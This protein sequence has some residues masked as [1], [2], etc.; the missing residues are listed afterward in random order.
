VN[1]SED[2]KEEG[3]LFPMGLHV[4]RG[5]TQVALDERDDESVLGGISL[6]QIADLKRVSLT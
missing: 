4:K 1:D 3:R 6:K 2:K 5:E